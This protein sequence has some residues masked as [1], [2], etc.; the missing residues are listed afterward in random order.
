[1][2]YRKIYE[3]T[4]GPIPTD[5]FGRTYDIHHKDGNRNN[6]CPTNLVALSIQEHY[7]THYAQGDHAACLILSYR[8]G[9]SKEDKSKLA[10]ESNRRRSAN[11][12]NPFCGPL[13]NKKKIKDG[14]HPWIGGEVSRRNALKLVEEGRH[15]FSGGK[16][17]SESNA[18]RIQEGNHNFLGGH[19]QRKQLAE[20]THNFQ[21]RVKCP[22]CDYENNAG[23][24]A[25]HI[26]KKHR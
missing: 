21:K 25:I 7:D 22:M 2:N 6:N 14:T 12:T 9:I 4:Y 3:E 26:R 24:V 5:E 10:S 23:N 8:L 17:Q 19:I 16:I 18:K 15:P 20:G 13:I 1:M 11:G